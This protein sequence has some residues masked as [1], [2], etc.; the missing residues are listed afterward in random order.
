M[1][2][3]NPQTHVCP[4]NWQWVSG[5]AGKG[6]PPPKHTHTNPSTQ[7]QPL[8]PSREDATLQVSACHDLYP[9]SLPMTSLCGA[10]SFG[11]NESFPVPIKGPLVYLPPSGG[12]GL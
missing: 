5:A 1:I 3:V 12:L 4:V 11:A 6:S 9:P 10:L 2:L 7:T 8:P